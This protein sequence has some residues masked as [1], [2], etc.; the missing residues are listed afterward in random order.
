MFLKLF[1]AELF[2][3]SKLK[4]PYILIIVLLIIAVLMNLV[5]LKFDFLGVI[6]MD[7]ETFMALTGEGNSMEGVSDAAQV[8]AMLGSNTVSR[9]EGTSILGKGVFYDADVPTLFYMHV[10]DLNPIMLLAIFI[11]IFVGDIYNTGLTKN[12]VISNNRRNL[13]F[14]ARFAV[15]AIYTTIIHVLTWI[16]TLI[17]AAMWAKEVDFN[18]NGHTVAYIFF[19]WFLTLVFALLV[20]AITALTRSKAAGITIGVVLSTG[21]LTTAISVANWVIIRKFQLDSNFSISDYMLTENLSTVNNEFTSGDITRALIV[22]CVY[23]LICI[24]AIVTV[25]RK[26]DIV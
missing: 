3:A 18:W 21:I 9:G 11:G 26:R 13:L 25:N 24:A 8:G 22:G 20:Y 10:S 2:R 12:Y 5:L 15:I 4:S 23:A 1:K 16:F 14:A 7:S 19:S 6:G 17:G